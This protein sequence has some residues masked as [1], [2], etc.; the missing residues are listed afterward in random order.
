[1]QPFTLTAGPLTLDQPTEADIPAIVEY[2]QD[3]VFERFMAIPWPYQRK[4]AE[5]FVHR[6][7]PAGW[8]YSAEFTWALRE[9]DGTFLGVVGIRAHNAMIGFWLGAP[10]RGHGYMPLAVSA[11]ADWAFSSGRPGF[12]TV[13]WEAV[14]GNAASLT[15]ARKTGFSYI[16]IAPAIV[17]ARDG[18]SPPSWQAVLRAADGREQKPGWPALD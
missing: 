2:C 9:A 11:V 1:M 17:T 10:H 13:R 15:V 18:S 5:Y 14:E 8:E 6:F 16:G 12:D 4:D 3:P 7:V